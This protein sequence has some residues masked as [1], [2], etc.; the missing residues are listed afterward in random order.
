[1]TA[2]QLRALRKALS[3]N[4]LIIHYAR[5]KSPTAALCGASTKSSVVADAAGVAALK[6]PSFECCACQEI[7]KSSGGPS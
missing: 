1:M 4:P 7:A 3:L 2:Q 6:M 5:R